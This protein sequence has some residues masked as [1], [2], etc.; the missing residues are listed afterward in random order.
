MIDTVLGNLREFWLVY[1]LLALYTVMLAHH[2]WTGKR[3]TKGLTDYYVG[4]RNMGGWVIGLSFFAT[5]AS[6]NSFVGFSGQTYDWGVPW[7]LFVPASVALSLFAWLI[8]AP[9]LRSFTRAMDSLT[10]PDFI[11]FRFDS[12]PARVFAA[13]ILIAA[14]FFYM[15]AVF[16]G[17]GNLLEVFLEIPYKLSIVIVFFVVMLYT[18]IGGF[19]SVVKTDSVQGVVMIMA[20]IL[21]FTGTVNAAGGLNAIFEVRSQAG[22]EALFTW[23]GGVAIPVL[24]GTMFAALIKFA[25]EP[26]QLARFFALQGDKAI[27]TGMLVSTITFGFVFSLLIPIGLYARRIFP[28]GLGDTDLVI[29]NLLSQVFGQGTA[30]FL[31]VAMVAAAM[32]SLDSVLLVL[33]STAERDIV[34]VIKPGR[35]EK[36]QMFWTKGWVALFAFITM[37]ISLNPPGGIVTLTA[38]SGS[39]YGACF[40]PAIVFGLHWQR[41]SGSAVITSFGTGIV[42]L[43]TWDFIPG[44]E[45]VHEVF[46]AMLLSTVAYA[47]ISLVT[48]DSASNTVV[49]LM[50]NSSHSL[51][52]QAPE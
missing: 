39:L 28:D 10:I 14:S 49:T 35:S 36:D 6:T 40:F 43:L 37:L 41:G 19:I 5:Y 29:P 46:P 20:A 51:R 23:G 13:L 12:T 50:K 25:V 27:R 21:L 11:G 26:R 32:S 22:G 24:L 9:R 44:S 1:S 30:A 31:L 42:T 7:M 52:N 34:S 38:F 8:I 33:A 15:T 47:G 3:E 16:K 2:A 4:G 48:R 45:V 18:M 17:I